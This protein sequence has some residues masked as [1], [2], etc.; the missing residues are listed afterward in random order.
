MLKTTQPA[1][2]TQT[3]RKDAKPLVP[4]LKSISLLIVASVLA[5]IWF[6][7]FL[8]MLSASLKQPLEIF[9]DGLNLI[10]KQFRWENYG[11]A[12]QDAGFNR[13]LLNSVLVTAGTTALVLVQ[14]SLTGYVLGRYRFLG[15]KLVIAILV[16]TLFVPVG[17][18]IIPQVQIAQALGLLNS[19]L[20]MIVV[21]GA[22]GH[23]TSILLFTGFFNRIPKELEEAAVLDGAGFVTIFW[24][25][26]VPLSMPIIATVTLLTFLGSW[27]NFFIPLVFTFSRPELRTLSVGMLAF[28][29]Q[30]ETDWSGMAAGATIALLPIMIM[31]LFLQRYYVEG[32][33]GA[34]KA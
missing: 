18:T 33:A 8:W 27:N 31:F 2:L 12:W 1:A 22:A 3:G 28:V 17:Y 34:V 14:T 6:Y 7:P 15:K 32:V 26:M 21:M 10:P 11:R 23:T 13:Y 16:G 4:W 19:L 20:G 30:N 5:L 29:G 25:I 24:R 9:S